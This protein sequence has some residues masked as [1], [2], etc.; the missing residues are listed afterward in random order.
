MFAAMCCFCGGWLIGSAGLAMGQYWIV[1]LGYGL[2]GGI[3]W[4]MV[5]IVLAWVW[6]AVP[7]G[8]RVY[9]LMLKVSKLF[10]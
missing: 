9:E 7:F 1:L 3:G 10:T 5:C 4:G 6:V 8:Y 2:I